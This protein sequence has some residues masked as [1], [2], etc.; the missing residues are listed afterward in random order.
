M[1]LH[2]LFLSISYVYCFFRHVNNSKDDINVKHVT[3]F[4]RHE[5]GCF[6]TLTPAHIQV[7]FYIH[8][9][10]VNIYFPE[11][12]SCHASELPPLCTFIVS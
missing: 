4:T 1:V 7:H 5:D 6:L 3:W 9:E 2:Y 10:W 8:P 11:N 12:L